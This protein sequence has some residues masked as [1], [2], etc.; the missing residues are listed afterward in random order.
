VPSGLDDLG[1]VDVDCCREI[2]LD[3]QF[4]LGHSISNAQ[5]A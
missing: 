4:E 1:V 2:A 5:E 3:A